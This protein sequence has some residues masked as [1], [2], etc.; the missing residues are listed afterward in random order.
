MTTRTSSGV[1]AAVRARTALVIEDDA[2]IRESLANLLEDEEFEVMT[3]STLQRAR[4]ILFESSHPVG[5]VV[6]DLGMPDGDGAA[7]AEELCERDQQ[8]VPVVLLSADGIRA[9]KLAVSLGI[10]SI[11]KPYDAD[12][13]AAAI[14][15]A[16]ENDVRPYLRRNT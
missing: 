6:L 15:M 10:P 3:A 9:E 11:A 13:T 12:R 7:L 14:T 5:V 16:F 8:S 1:R 2:T 4:Y